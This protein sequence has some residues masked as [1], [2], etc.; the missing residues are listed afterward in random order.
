M[1]DVCV[2]PAQDD[3]VEATQKRTVHYRMIESS[4]QSDN[5][6]ID[7]HRHTSGETSCS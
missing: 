1:A 7:V 5:L 4:P 2:G 6:R 3:L